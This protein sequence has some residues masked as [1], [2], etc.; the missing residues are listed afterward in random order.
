TTIGYNEQS[1]F[2][3]VISSQRSSTDW[4]GYDNNFRDREHNNFVTANFNPS[5]YQVFNALGLGSYYSSIGVTQQNW[6]DGTSTG[7]LNFKLGLIKIGL[8]PAALIN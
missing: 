7:D 2:K 8:L 3:N 6:G 5:Q 4:M 1:T